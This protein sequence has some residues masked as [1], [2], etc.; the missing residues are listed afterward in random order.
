MKTHR[1]ETKKKP[2]DWKQS[3]HIFNALTNGTYASCRAGIVGAA[4]IT[5]DPSKV[6]CK[7]C[8]VLANVK[9]L[10]PAGEKT[11]ITPQND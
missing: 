2:E 9:V 11:P 1:K 4:H 7:A 5:E 10:A 6:T 8:L 3:P